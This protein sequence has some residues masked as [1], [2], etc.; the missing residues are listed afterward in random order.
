MRVCFV[1][2]GLARFHSRE[3]VCGARRF[4]SGITESE[5]P[6]PAMHSGATRF[7]ADDG[8]D[9][10]GQGSRP[11]YVYVQG[12][13]TTT[14]KAA[15]RLRSSAT[16]FKGPTFKAD[17]IQGRPTTS[18]IPRPIPALHLPSPTNRRRF[19]PRIVYPLE[20]RANCDIFPAMR[21]VPQAVHTFTMS[22]ARLRQRPSLY[23]TSPPADLARHRVPNY[24]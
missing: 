16:P 15:V 13:R 2:V 22:R 7:K 10:D 17:Y 12:R 8:G 21:T 14:F 4:A 23:R 19:A 20:A 5:R 1:C 11:P 3:V 6:M 24:R 9:D 18:S